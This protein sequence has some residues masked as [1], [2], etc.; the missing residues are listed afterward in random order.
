MSVTSIALSGLNA[1]EKRL[2]VSANNVANSNT[3]TTRD[4][5]G[6]TINEAFRAQTVVQSAQAGGGVRADVRTA[7]NPTLR[8]AAAAGDPL[9]DADGTIEIPNVSLDE[10]AVNQITASYD[11]KANLKV[12]KVQDNLTQSLLD[13][14]A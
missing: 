13:I 2:S 3:T 10:E 11:F 6:N 1:A 5:S 14:V 4:S 12:L 9:A 8:V 7:D